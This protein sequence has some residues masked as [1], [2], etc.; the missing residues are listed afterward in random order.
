MLA[1]EWVATAFLAE[2]PARPV[3]GDE[4]HLVPEREEPLA[5]RAQQRGMIAARKVGAADGAAKEDVADLGESGDRVEKD[6]VAWGVTWAVQDLEHALTD[7]DLLAVLEPSIRAERR[8][9][10]QAEELRLLRECVEPKCIRSVRSEDRN[11]E[12]FGKIRGG[13]DVIQVAVRKQDQPR[14]RAQAIDR[15]EDALGLAARVDDRGVA[16]LRAREDRAILLER[17][18]RDDFE[19]HRRFS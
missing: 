8:L 18:D 7:L 16:R 15:V 1:H 19:A 9:M 13:A 2:R 12:S 3:S 4:P 14:R 17:R 11:P 10:W 5:D 6:Q